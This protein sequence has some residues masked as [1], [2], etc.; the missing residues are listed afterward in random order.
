MQ[1]IFTE[2]LEQVTSTG[3][4]TVWLKWSLSSLPY[5]FTLDLQDLGSSISLHL[6][7]TLE[8]SS[9]SSLFILLSK[10]EQN[11]LP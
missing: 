2:S 7:Q 8:A 1:Y 5:L 3:E 4:F 9:S 6:G 11:A 10:Y